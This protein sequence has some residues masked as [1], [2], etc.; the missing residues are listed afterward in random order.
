VV[1][2]SGRGVIGGLSEV[3]N[4]DG[5]A[6]V[7]ACLPEGCV[8]SFLVDVPKVGQPLGLNLQLSRA[9]PPSAVMLLS[10]PFYVDGEALLS[11]VQREWPSVSVFGGLASGGEQASEVALFCDG[12]LADVGAVGVTFG[13]E[14]RFEFC[15]SAGG[16]GIGDPFIVTRHREGLIQEFDRGRPLDA[17]LQLH[18]ELGPRDQ[19]L[20]GKSLCVGLELES[21]S[22][23]QETRDYLIRNISGVDD[24]E[25]G[26]HV[27]A[28]VQD[29]Q[30]L[31]FFVR[32]AVTAAEDLRLRLEALRDRDDAPKRIAALVFSCVGRGVALYGREGHDSDLLREKLGDFPVGGLFC[33][34]EFGPVG[35]RSYLH[36]YTSVIA[37]VSET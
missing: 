30:V 15:V 36:G 24:E 4:G 17:L 18:E 14:L 6:L 5:V 10:N 27:A 31:R 29:Y 20:F 1:G 8:E 37:L 28:H 12:E 21:G 32:D 19:D 9:T 7:A 23:T 11:C 26:L 3:Q 34:G 33:N 25:R 22:G 35:A 2:A 13:E 16:R